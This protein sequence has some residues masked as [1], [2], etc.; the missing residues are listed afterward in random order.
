M[1]LF[2]KNN[3]QRLQMLNSKVTLLLKSKHRNKSCY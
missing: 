2:P 1:Q 3:K